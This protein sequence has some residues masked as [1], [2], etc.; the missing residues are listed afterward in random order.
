MA[1]A[2][3]GA[4]WLG[5]LFALLMLA[6]GAIRAAR[7]AD[8]G[9][10]PRARVLLLA[11]LLLALAAG[12]AW[13]FGAGVAQAGLARISHEDGAGGAGAPARARLLLR[14]VQLHLETADP[15][16]APAQALI[17]WSPAASLRLPRTYGLREA[18]HG[19]DVVRL[20]AAGPTALRAERLALPEAT[21]TR[22]LLA[23][24]R[25]NDPGRAASDLIDPRTRRCR[26]EVSGA[27]AEAP[28]LAVV[29]CAGEEPRAALLIERD[30][31]WKEASP[32]RVAVRVA[33][34]LWQDGAWHPHSIPIS[35]GALVQMGAVAD[36]VP[37]VTLWE[38][39]APAART[40]LFVPPQSLLLPCADWVR[41]SER[42][43]LGGEEPAAAAPGPSEPPEASACVLPFTPPFGLEVRRL[44][45]AVAAVAARSLWAQGL[46]AAPALLA[47]LLLATLP[48]SALGA[49]RFA[50]LAALAWMGSLLGALNTLRLLL[51]HRI[52]VMRRYDAVGPL[53]LQNE[54]FVVMAAGALAAAV[55]LTWTP[56]AHRRR[57]LVGALG[58]WALT[59]A[60]GS[61]A[62]LA[63][64]HL[65]WGPGELG[66]TLGQLLLS[67]FCGTLPAW[68]PW[69]RAR[70]RAGQPLLLRWASRLGVRDPDTVAAAL[71]LGAVAGLL[72]L[73]GGRASVLA[74]VTAAW[75]VV[76]IFYRGLRAARGDGRGLALLG[77]ALAAAALA[78]GARDTGVTV[79]VVTPGLLATA[80]L[81]S[82]DGAYLEGDLRAQGGYRAYA[83]LLRAQAVC[84]LLA[85]I[86]VAIW[87]GRALL[88]GLASGEPDADA[89]RQ[90]T[91]GALYLLLPVAALFAVAAGETA[92]RG[93]RRGALGLA[94][95]A[96]AILAAFA[97]RGPLLGRALA[98]HTRAAERLALVLDP[99]YALLKSERDFVRGLSSW[100]ET[101][102]PT[103]DEGPKSGAAVAGGQGYFGAH[104]A[105][106]G[107][108]HSLENDYLPVLIL[109]EL[110]VFGLLLT[111]ALLLSAA[112]GLG[113]LGSVRFRHGSFAG[114]ARLLAA[115]ILGTLCLYQP[116]A[117]I[118]ALPLTGIAW[119]GLGLNSPT[120]FWLLVV[121]LF[122]ASA[123]GPPWQKERLDELDGE[124]RAGRVFRATERWTLG[125]AGAVGLA[126]LM[127]LARA[128]VFA[129]RRPGAIAVFDGRERLVAPFQG[130]SDAVDYV[131]RLAC[132]RPELEGSSP[133]DV[134]PHELLGD[135]AAAPGL[136]RFH[137]AFVAAW[138]AE[139]PRLVAALAAG[140]ACR[141]PR[142]FGHFRLEP[143]T[144]D[145]A[146][147]HA[148]FKYGWPEVHVRFRRSPGE[149]LRAR[150]EVDVRAEPLAALR[151][152]A[153]PTSATGERVRLV[154]R[155]LGA[156]AADVGELHG[157]RVVIRLRPG[158]SGD[159]AL[160]AA[161]A[162][163]GI[164]LASR[165]DLSDELT[166]EIA[167][168]TQKVRLSRKS[169]G[170]PV[171][172]PS[173]LVVRQ[174][175][176]ERLQVAEGEDGRW[177]VHPLEGAAHPQPLD[178]L[179]LVV[180]GR[181]RGRNV[182]LFRPAQSH[183]GGAPTAEPLLA[184]DVLTA[185]GERFR[186]YTYGGLLPE[187]GWVN[188]YQPRLSLG[189]DGWVHVAV[190]EHAAA[191]ALADLAGGAARPDDT[192]GAL[193]SFQEA[194]CG[195]LRPFGSEAP[196]AEAARRTWGRVCARSPLDGVLECQVSLQ[197]ELEIR[198]R[199]LLELASLEPEKFP[200]LLSGRSARPPARAEFALL[201]GN[202]GEIL[203]RGDFVAG[204]QST[205]YA[206]ASPALTQYLV[207][208]REG[209]D[210]R[211]GERLPQGGE[212]GAL[213]ADWSEPIPIGSTL[214][215]LLARALE[216]A[217]P[218]FVERLHLDAPDPHA[219]GGC[220]GGWPA[221]LGHCPPT[222]SIWDEGGRGAA[223][224]P[225][226]L[227]ESLNWFQ[228]AL[229]LLGTAVPSGSLGFG[230]LTTATSPAEI[231]WL[232]L[233][234]HSEKDALWTRQNG[235][236]VIGAHHGVTL[237]ALRQTPLWRNFEAL[238]G[239]P[240]CTEKGKQSCRLAG[241]RLDLCAAR[242][243]PI[244]RPGADL[245]HLVATGPAEFD[246]LPE[247][248][249][250]AAGRV[251]SVPVTEYFQ[252]LRGAGVH[253]LGSTLQ[254]ADA[255][256][257]LFYERD[258]GPGG[259]Y[260]LAAS[261]FPVDPAGS[262]PTW[263][264][265]DGA[266]GGVAGGLC[267]VVTDPSG[268]GRRLLPL[269]QEEGIILYGAKTGTIDALRDLAENAS[270]CA[271]YNE[272]HRL[273]EESPAAP[274]GTRLASE[275]NRYA[276]PCGRAGAARDIND[277]LLAVAF[278][279]RQQAGVQPLLLVLRFQGTG[280]GY[281]TGVARPFIAAIRA[282]F[283]GGA[284]DPAAASAPH[285]VSQPALPPR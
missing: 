81:A 239:R 200:P 165:V 87:A 191:T 279:V 16:T 163:P 282:Y 50:R 2:L 110:G 278:G 259:A 158:S 26:P 273:P 229:G 39:P 37:G 28:A 263:S 251:A 166:L 247:G 197:P 257:R 266:P 34:L 162:Q 275:S 113:I 23:A 149:P 226:Y 150:C 264:C 253:P 120:D 217:D 280:Q 122:A 145:P 134:V 51:A 140:P 131:H 14:Y 185:R 42:G 160:D 137:E 274:R 143:G 249:R 9:P 53:T 232:Q 283:A 194:A 227:A 285:A 82:H 151:Q 270:A 130:L 152:P 207:R 59:I 103:G 104:I 96:A 189:L 182:W 124:L 55:V 71:A 202:T 261:W 180:T 187:L 6:T 116:L 204:R 25:T 181:A 206:P 230:D 97:A 144:D 38:L 146:E 223:S 267:G 73:L 63:D 54:T 74:K 138:R 1:K 214:K 213:K 277:S 112:L 203:A 46:C 7:R 57:E 135:P 190:A 17:G 248:A 48:R 208:A 118:G 235:R 155:P 36:A 78:L 3:I 32:L 58:A 105:D 83:P 265:R 255:Y 276:L 199:H 224:L 21:G 114:R 52:D 61:L 222:R 157:G 154:A 269:L 188:P 119:P 234:E 236:T 209:R 169:G 84:V 95:V 179:A 72:L 45:P 22:V 171:R 153:R 233:A 66:K 212:P 284:A 31:P 70:L 173:W 244:P 11:A 123:W 252:F 15:R 89:A 174:A 281:A 219:R 29:L 193:A 196:P 198:L 201:A 8:A 33:P 99:A 90:L 68:L 231:S 218:D 12:G 216:R 176:S 164:Y 19:W 142:T 250:P 102:L 43:F 129:A 13:L 76:L 80:I 246:F 35:P 240:L 210:P 262:A 85:A 86:G 141:G 41:S 5:G 79:A 271:S 272:A 109:R 47:L 126:A 238:V 94:L 18:T 111:E 156:A 101:R 136:A 175:Q 121:L 211:T 183:D 225:R 170:Q 161:R 115:V 128:G 24:A 75:A 186:H 88:S 77:G 64:A 4:L 133:E 148:T 65:L 67:L 241:D 205:A 40:E 62:L 93:R 192:S 132:D 69:L 117:A 237:E 254:L 147:C 106:A 139:R 125:A 44:L 258:P 92:R 172:V 243:L 167:P 168:G 20:G 100:S 91:W 220:R 98:T 56:G 268:T 221:L 60:V 215:P 27:P 245:R 127:V 177:S 256:N 260:R 242:A 107:V 10:P 159:K 108:R 49:G 30:L 184:D 195:T 228:A 178:S